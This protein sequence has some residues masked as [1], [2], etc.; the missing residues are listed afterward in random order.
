MSN[1]TGAGGHRVRSRPVIGR[2]RSQRRAKRVRVGAVERRALVLEAAYMLA[3]RPDVGLMAITWDDVIRL[4]AVSTSRMTARRSFGSL[5][6][7]RK[8]V[9]EHGRSLHDSDIV[10]QGERYGLLN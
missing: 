10:Q 5:V 2:R 3:K 1:I 8:A 6:A 7:L 9:V 4:C